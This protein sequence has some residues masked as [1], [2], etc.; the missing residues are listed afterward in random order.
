MSNRPAQAATLNCSNSP[1]KSKTNRSWSPIQARSTTKL[2]SSAKKQGLSLLL[3][4]QLQPRRFRSWSCHYSSRGARMSS[5]WL[6]APVSRMRAKCL[7]LT[8]I[9]GSRSHRLMRSLRQK[10]SQIVFTPSRR[11]TFS[12]QITILVVMVGLKVARLQT[13]PC[14]VLN[15]AKM[16][17]L[18]S[19][20]INSSKVKITHG[21]KT[22]W[23]TN[24]IF[25]RGWAPWCKL[26][27]VTKSHYL[28]E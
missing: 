23:R 18:N 21:K 1:K 12:L 17:N 25:S 28:I 8:T 14:I 24:K 2:G 19:Q 15:Q 11:S 22:R 13:N 6:E 20:I 27:K 9:K 5:S 26:K 4:T 16:L 7:S 3:K 10:R